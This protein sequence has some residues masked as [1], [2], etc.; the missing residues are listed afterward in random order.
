MHSTPGWIRV[1]VGCCKLG[2]KIG[3]P[4]LLDLR[5]YLGFAATHGVARRW[6]IDVTHHLVTLR[7]GKGRVVGSLMG[8]SRG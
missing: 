8:K 2:L 7:D 1:S 3:T 5:V 6:A 4:L